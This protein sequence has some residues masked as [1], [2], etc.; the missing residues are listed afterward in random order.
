MT[1]LNTLLGALTGPRRLRSALRRKTV[2]ISSLL[3]ALDGPGELR[4]SI[5]P[6]VF[7]GDIFGVMSSQL[8]DAL[9]VPQAT[10]PVTSRPQRK[11]SLPLLE[12]PFAKHSQDVFSS[13]DT[14]KKPSTLTSETF[15][16]SRHSE[17]SS[18]EPQASVADSIKEN[19]TRPVT[20]AQ[21]V[22][23]AFAPAFETPAVSRLGTIEQPRS[24]TTRRTPTDSALVNSLNRY[25]QAVRDERET[26]RSQAQPLGA[27]LADRP[28]FPVAD[29][30]QRT[31]P[32]AWP[33]SVGRDVSQKLRSFTEA[34]IPMKSR[35]SSAPDRGIQ[36]VFNIEVNHANHHSSSFDDLGDRIAQIL[37]EQAL[38]HGIDVT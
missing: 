21:T 6:A 34:D 14:R 13:M 15:A 9:I 7:G 30:E 23:H 18:F 8:R 4:V 12:N 20:F 16:P 19:L 5:P 26:S 31:A 36:N 10:A 3:V 33:T 25:W 32:R 29:A 37:H 2:G 17:G 24:V 1:E 38:Q 11:Q 22:E 35:I 27:S 28:D